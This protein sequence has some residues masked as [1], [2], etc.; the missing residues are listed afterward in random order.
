[1]THVFHRYGLHSEQSLLTKLHANWQH[2]VPAP[3]SLVA[4]YD[5]PLAYLIHVL[6]PTYVP[7]V[8]FRFHLLTY[9]LY[10]AVV[11][12]E[13][14]FA[15]SGYNMLPS[16]FILGGVA[17]RQEKHLMGGGNG[18]YGCF[19][20]VDFAMGTSIGEGMVDDVIDEVEEKQVTKKTKSKVKAAG[21]KVLK[22]APK[23][24]NDDEEVRK[25][26]KGEGQGSTEEDNEDN[27]DNEENEEDEEE[28]EEEEEEASLKPKRKGSSPE[29]TRKKG[30]GSHDEEDANG[31]SPEAKDDS[32]LKRSSRTRRSE[33]K[34]KTS[35]EDAGAGGQDEEKPEPKPKAKG[36]TRKGSQK[37]KVGSRPRN[38][39]EEDDE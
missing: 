23:Q 27:E 28:E 29:K 3:F 14:T 7:A 9:L 15:Y 37:N 26:G 21:K 1:M 35:E 31:R 34:K 12:L 5:H 4:H 39:S 30:V 8:I 25:A 24:K 2:A 20:L 18:N 16:A 38:R 10:L 11:S 33:K 17:R 32:P 13:E 6:L 36:L 22:K 19:G